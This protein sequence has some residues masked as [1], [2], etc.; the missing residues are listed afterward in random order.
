MADG[1]DM[2]D[3]RLGD[4]VKELSRANAAMHFLP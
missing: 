4:L 3:C 2:A 1:S